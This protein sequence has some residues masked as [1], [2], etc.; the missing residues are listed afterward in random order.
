[1]ENELEEYL[2]KYQTPES[3]KQLLEYMLNGKASPFWIFITEFLIKNI[4]DLTEAVLDPGT[5]E[6]TEVD[7]L[8]DKIKLQKGLL[9]LPDTIIDGLGAVATEN[10][11]NIEVYE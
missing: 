10:K 7:R 6:A 4:E 9:K 1:M 5:I 3:R 11:T 8:R 2:T